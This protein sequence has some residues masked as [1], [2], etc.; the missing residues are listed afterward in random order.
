MGKLVYIISYNFLFKS[1]WTQ[2]VNLFIYFD[3]ICL[4]PMRGHV[5]YFVK[6]HYVS[7]RNEA[8]RACSVFQK[9]MALLPGANCIKL[10]KQGLPIYIVSNDLHI[11]VDNK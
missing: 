1:A 2:R 11:E 3:T 7:T 8:I 6:F 10:C 9:L 5:R 4:P